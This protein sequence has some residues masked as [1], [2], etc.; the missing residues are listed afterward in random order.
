MEKFS[1]ALH[2][3]DPVEVNNFL[4]NVISQVEKIIAASKQ[5]DVYIANLEK[6]INN[7]DN[8]KAEL[9]HYKRME[10]NLNKTIEMAQKTSE[11]MK[12]TAA[13]E[14][15]LIVENAKRHADRIVNNALMKADDTEREAAM[16][17]RN[18]NLFKRKLKDT[19]EQQLEMVNDIEKIDF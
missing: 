10:E 2:G 19:L 1:H 17:R 4:D 8:L 5:K 3:Y 12:I 7:I 11:Q 6:Q 15:E 16:L 18:I 13:K 14:G 9:E